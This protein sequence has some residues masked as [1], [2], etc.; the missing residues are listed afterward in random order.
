MNARRLDPTA[1]LMGSATPDRI[2][3]GDIGPGPSVAGG[4]T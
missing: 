4:M 1:P 3:C 2:A